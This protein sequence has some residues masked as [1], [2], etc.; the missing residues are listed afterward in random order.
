MTS[1][2][3]HHGNLKK[4][5]IAAG[6]DIL[7]EKG[8]E[9][10]SLRKV[11]K[12]V[13]VSHTAP[14][15][16]FTDKQA[17]LAAISTAG[18]EQLHKTLQH[19]FEAI[20]DASPNIIEEIA[21]SFFQFAL[22]NPGRYNLMFSGALDEERNHPKYLEISQKNISL[23]E[24]IITYCQNKGQINPGNVELIAIRLWSTIH[25]FNY[26]ILDN[27]FPNEYTKGQNLKD[28]LKAIISS[29]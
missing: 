24:E 22:E 15:N 20:K 6:L 16:H 19:K 28:L 10:L 29:Q 14:Y 18:H 27:Q 4:A 21:W 26:L 13:G 3:Y 25:G 2:T 9:G 12:K 8:I 1:N 11:A 23:I 5:L 7:S 17:L